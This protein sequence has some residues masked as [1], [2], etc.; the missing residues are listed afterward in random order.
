MTNKAYKCFF[1]FVDLFQLL[2][3]SPQ[4]PMFILEVYFAATEKG[5][6]VE[7]SSWLLCTLENSH[8]C[9]EGTLLLC[10]IFEI[11]WVDR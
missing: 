8:N 7:W 1:K 10:G 2:V 4:E 5:P 6:D 9:I 11:L 3:T